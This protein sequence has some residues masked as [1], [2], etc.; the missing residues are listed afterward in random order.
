[1]HGASSKI[2]IERKVVRQQNDERPSGAVTVR[3]EAVTFRPSIPGAAF[4][5]SIAAPASAI[6]KEARVGDRKDCRANR[7]GALRPQP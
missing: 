3:R 5:L 2:L 6:I 4:A 7:G 1:M